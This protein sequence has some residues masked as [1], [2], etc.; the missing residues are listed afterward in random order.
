MRKALQKVYD[1]EFLMVLPEILTYETVS[2]TLILHLFVTFYLQAFSE[3]AIRRHHAL[4]VR[5]AF[6]TVATQ[7]SHKQ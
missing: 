5:R 4:L 2:G 6:N 3:F 1:Q 7:G